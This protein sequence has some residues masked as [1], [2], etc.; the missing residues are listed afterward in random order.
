MVGSKQHE[1][2]G[3]VLGCQLECLSG[4]G[5][6]VLPED[7]ALGRPKRTCQGKYSQLVAGSPRDQISVRWMKVY[8]GFKF[9][10]NLC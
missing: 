10:W 3:R 7:E 6:V 4:A 1:T 9:G 2:P 5:T 8:G